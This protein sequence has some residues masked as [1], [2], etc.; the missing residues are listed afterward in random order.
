LKKDSEGMEIEVN[1]NV[2]VAEEHG[3]D[4]DSD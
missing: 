2:A 4:E 1:S 3:D